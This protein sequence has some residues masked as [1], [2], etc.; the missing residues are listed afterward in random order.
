MSMKSDIY[1]KYVAKHE[2]DNTALG[3][4]PEFEHCLSAKRQAEILALPRSASWGRVS[5]RQGY[6]LPDGRVIEIRNGIWP[7]YSAYAVV[8]QNEA[9]HRG[10]YEIMGPTQYF[11]G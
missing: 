4:E 6:L 10:Y 2:A 7:I 5:A 11:E 8:Y 9:H 1:A 3:G